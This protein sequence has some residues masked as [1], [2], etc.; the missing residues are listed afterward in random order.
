MLESGKDHGESGEVRT[1]QITT[2]TLGLFFFSPFYCRFAQ[3]FRRLIS[4][5]IATSE[6]TQ[7]LDCEQLYNGF[8]I[9]HIIFVCPNTSSID[10]KKL[11]HV[12]FGTENGAAHELNQDEFEVKLPY[13][14]ALC[15]YVR[16]NF[17]WI[18]LNGK[19]Y[20]FEV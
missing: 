12:L 9:D 19:T 3:E 13:Q 7:C 5:D 2:E 15:R 20:D 17:N 11:T 8:Y 1:L 4:D 6:P 16:H 18:Q 10:R 14:K